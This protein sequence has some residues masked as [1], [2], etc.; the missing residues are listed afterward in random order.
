MFLKVDNVGAE[1][2][3]SGILFQATGPA[4]E[5]MPGC[6][7]VALSTPG[8]ERIAANIYGQKTNSRYFYNTACRWGQQDFH[9]GGGGTTKHVHKSRHTSQECIHKEM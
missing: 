4:T 2:V 3:C 6:R 8:Y 1:P 5:K 7:V 9:P